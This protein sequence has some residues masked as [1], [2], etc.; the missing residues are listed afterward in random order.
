[1]RLVDRLVRERGRASIGAGDRDLPEALAA[2]D[3]GTRFQ[4]QVGV[5]ERV[6]GIR[7]APRPAI[8]SDADDVG[9]GIEVAASRPSL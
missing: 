3:V 6:V 9:C 7:V 1:M 8:D 5:I 4:W 2:D